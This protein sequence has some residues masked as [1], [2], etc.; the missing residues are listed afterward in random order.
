MYCI[1]MYTTLRK[2]RFISNTAQ[3]HAICIHK[4]LSQH[5]QT[6]VVEQKQQKTIKKEEKKWKTM[7]NLQTAAAAAK[8]EALILYTSFIV[9][10]GI[11]DSFLLLFISTSACIRTQSEYSFM[12]LYMKKEPKY[13]K[14]STSTTSYTHTYIE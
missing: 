6:G 7:N 5:K 2:P 14:E 10:L 8:P 13:N 1:F 12:R 3:V 4:K 9:T 11:S